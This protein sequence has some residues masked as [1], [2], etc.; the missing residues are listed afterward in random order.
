MALRQCQAKFVELGWCRAE[1]NR[2]TYIV[3]QMFK[4]AVGQELIPASVLM[5]LQAVE[6]L[7]PGRCDAPDRPPVGPVDDATVE[8]TLA[9]VSPTIRAMAMLQL[10]TG[11]RPDEVCRL[12]TGDLTMTGTTWEYKPQRH[13]NQHRGKK[14]VIIIGPRGQSLLRDWLKPDLAAP[15]FPTPNGTFYATGIYRQ[16]IRRGCDR[17]FPHPI[18]GS[19]PEDDLTDDQRSEL[20]AWRKSHR[21]SPNQLRHAT[22]TKLRRNAGVETTRTVLGHEKLASTEVYAERDL[23]T[24]RQAM[25]AYG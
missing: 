9:K 12:T 3:R 13:K 20:D 7:R 8:A 24:A 23:E 5:A 15:I 17:A 4:W 21:W 11:M 22:A 10:L 1:V 6:G 16:A 25:E 19:I 14:R 2:A 18:L